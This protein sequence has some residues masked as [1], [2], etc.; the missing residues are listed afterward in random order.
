M[1]ISVSYDGRSATHKQRSQTIQRRFRARPRGRLSAFRLVLRILALP[2]IVLQRKIQKK[3]EVS[4]VRDRFGLFFLFCAFNQV[5]KGIP[6]WATALLKA[7][8]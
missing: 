7:V 8:R 2:G 5:N 1:S 3:T 6:F 4:L